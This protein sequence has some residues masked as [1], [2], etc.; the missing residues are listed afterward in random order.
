MKN[1]FL[2]KVK[3]WS[4]D[5]K[6]RTFLLALILMSLLLFATQW[7]S[8]TET[9]QAPELPESADTYIPAGFVLV[10]IELQNADA[11]SS[12]ISS[13]A[14]VDLFT[15]AP[16]TRSQRVGK[17]LKLLRAPLNPQQFAVL[18]PENDVSLLLS[19]SGAYWAAIQNPNEKASSAVTKKSVNRI[20][21][22][23]GDNE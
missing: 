13:Y 23:Q 21:Y 19:T 10:P 18:V 8:K 17:R 15:G 7:L 22:F 16:G 6:N 1:M 11:L 14:L 2:E 4:R 5:A 3:S 20:E 9:P 12:L